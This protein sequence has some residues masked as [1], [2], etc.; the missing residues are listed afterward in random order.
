[1]GQRARGE[2]ISGDEAAAMKGYRQTRRKGRPARE[3]RTVGGARIQAKAAAR[4]KGARFSAVIVAAGALCFL[5]G[6][7]LLATAVG[8]RTAVSG[9]YF[10]GLGAAIVAGHPVSVLLARRRWTSRVTVPLDRTA[11]ASDA[12]GDGAVEA[13]Q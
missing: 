5:V 12:P 8:A 2:P 1:M 7:V 9:L 10:A 4:W 3:L 6:L 13:G 11:Q